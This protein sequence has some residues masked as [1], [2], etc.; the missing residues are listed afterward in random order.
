MKPY[1]QISDFV[2]DDSKRKK[3]ISVDDLADVETVLSHKEENDKDKIEDIDF[4]VALGDN[5][6]RTSSLNSKQV[7]E[8]KANCG[9]NA[10]PQSFYDFN[11]IEKNNHS[12]II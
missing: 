6:V 9:G 4:L 11:D 7:S 1:A 3:N 10:D 5:Q 2:L 8:N 12:I